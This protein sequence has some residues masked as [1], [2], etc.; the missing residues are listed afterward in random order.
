MNYSTIPLTSKT[1]KD[2]DDIYFPLRRKKKI[3]SYDSVIKLLMK[4][5][6]K[7]KEERKLHI[8]QK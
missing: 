1:R 3:R 5:Y 8:D 6:Y 4:Y 7:Y 2:L